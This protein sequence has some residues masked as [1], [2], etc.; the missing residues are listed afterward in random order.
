[1]FAALLYASKSILYHVQMVDVCGVKSTVLPVST[2][3]DK[4]I[5]S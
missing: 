1:M 3:P 5:A 4:H 2:F